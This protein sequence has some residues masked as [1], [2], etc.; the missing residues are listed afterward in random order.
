MFKLPIFF[1]LGTLF[2]ALVAMAAPT[3][4]LEK[5]REMASPTQALPAA[6]M[7]FQDWKK[8]QVFDAKLNLDQFKS[9]QLSRAETVEVVKAEDPKMA[10]DKPEEPIAAVGEGKTGSLEEQA[11]AATAE[12]KADEVEQAA[13]KII[14]PLEK[15]EI[16]AKTEKLRQLEFN[17]EI[18]QGLTIHDYFALYLKNKDQNEMAQAIQQL[19]PDE[20]SQLLMA[21]RKNLYGVPAKEGPQ[22]SAMKKDL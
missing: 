9:P 21:Y 5:K 13:E 12:A 20:L 16:E 8:N 15:Q 19:S 10:E 2:V 17:L 18:A 11:L 7:G 22:K 6:P 3:Q 1:I 14:T 4:K